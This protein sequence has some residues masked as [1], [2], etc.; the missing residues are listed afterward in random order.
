MDRC[1]YSQTMSRRMRRKKS[2]A[3]LT[4][5]GETLGLEGWIRRPVSWTELGRAR[6]GGAF[7]VDISKDLVFYSEGTEEH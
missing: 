4:Q 3:V 7:G 5:S 6:S 1:F 2:K